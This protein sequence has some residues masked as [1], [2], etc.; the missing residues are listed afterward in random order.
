MTSKIEEGIEEIFE[1]LD[2]CKAAPLKTGKILVDKEEIYE[3]LQELKKNAPEE[4]K[5]IRK[6]VA[7]K[8]AILNDAKEKAEALG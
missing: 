8:E 4:I 2:N 6:I 1:Y 3:L 5:Q 7:N